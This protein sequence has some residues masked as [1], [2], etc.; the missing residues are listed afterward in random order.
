MKLPS[1]LEQNQQRINTLLDDNQDHHDPDDYGLFDTFKKINDKQMNQMDY[2]Q[3]YGQD[4][5]YDEAQDN[6]HIDN[7]SYGYRGTQNMFDDN[8][9][10]KQMEIRG[11]KLHQLLTDQEVNNNRIFANRYAGRG[12]IGFWYFVIDCTYHFENFL[13]FFLILLIFYG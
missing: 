13:L 1:L 2:E 7:G 11:G 10:K 6:N 5:I 9:F 8:Y 3:G 4:I 12:I